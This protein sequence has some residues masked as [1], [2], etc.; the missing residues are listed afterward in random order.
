MKLC[1]D[2][3]HCRGHWCIRNA[4]EAPSPVDGTIRTYNE[5]LCEVERQHWHRIPSCGP[6]AIYFESKAEVENE[7]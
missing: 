3:N 7:A 5:D 6:D 2:C 4:Y 1:I